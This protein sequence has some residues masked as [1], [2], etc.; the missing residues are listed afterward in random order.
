LHVV[1]ETSGGEQVSWTRD[2]CLAAGLDPII[3]RAGQRYNDR[4][5]AR[6]LWLLIAPGYRP[7]RTRYLLH[8]RISKSGGL[9][10]K[11]VADDFVEAL[12]K[13]EDNRDV[14]GLVAI[15]TEDCEVGAPPTAIPSPTTA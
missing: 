8:E 1:I 14:E 15:H 4:I 13:L 12:R 7:S 5:L 11:G 2:T 9:V 3:P 6:I 10:S